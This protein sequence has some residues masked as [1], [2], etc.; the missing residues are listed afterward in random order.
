MR[1][2]FTKGP[3][4]KKTNNISWKKAKSTTFEGLNGYIDMA[5]VLMESCGKVIDKDEKK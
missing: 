5:S 3:K 2:L 1:K 4:Y